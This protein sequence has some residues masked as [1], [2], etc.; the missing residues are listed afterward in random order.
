MLVRAKKLC[1]SSLHRPL[2]PNRIRQLRPSMPVIV[3]VLNNLLLHAFASEEIKK[4][5]SFWQK[6][7]VKPVNYPPVPCCCRQR[8]NP[9]G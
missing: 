3:L 7:S 5:N 8:Q 1:G 6:H 9:G 4:L 2:V